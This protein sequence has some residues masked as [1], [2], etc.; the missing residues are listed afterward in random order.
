[1]LGRK[2]LLAFSEPVANW[3]FE[4]GEIGVFASPGS[5]C[6][7]EVAWALGAE[8][9]GQ[10]IIEQA[11]GVL[12]EE[13]MGLPARALGEHAD[14]GGQGVHAAQVARAVHGGLVAL[15]AAG[16]ALVPDAA[17]DAVRAQFPVER[18]RAA[19]AVDGIDGV[20]EDDRNLLRG[21]LVRPRAAVP[22]VAFATVIVVV[23]QGAQAEAIGQEEITGQVVQVVVTQDLP[24]VKAPSA[25]LSGPLLSHF[26]ALKL[27]VLQ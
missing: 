22:V 18:Q 10:A 12:Q 17:F 3:L 16:V 7:S 20:A 15:G 27:A 25:S 1:M 13:L 9:Q 4:V 6:A 24:A 23:G 5:A 8:L 2:F 21:A 26:F 14:I 11:P 19:I